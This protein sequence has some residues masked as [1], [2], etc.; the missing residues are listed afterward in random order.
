LGS[1]EDTHGIY[2]NTEVNY[3]FKHTKYAIRLYKID[4]ME[5]ISGFMEVQQQTCVAK[6]T[7]LISAMTLNIQSYAYICVEG[8]MK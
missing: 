2:Y 1:S 7:L 5:I 4:F 6:D 8:N 3:N